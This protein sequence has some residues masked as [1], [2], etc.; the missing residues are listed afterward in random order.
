MAC[1]LGIG[2]RYQYF[3]SLFVVFSTIWTVFSFPFMYVKMRL[4]KIIGFLPD[5][6]IFLRIIPD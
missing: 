2:K 1:I 3:H 6:E 5:F 4:K